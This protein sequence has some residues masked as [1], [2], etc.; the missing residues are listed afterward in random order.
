M[1]TGIT[2]I[3]A[4]QVPEIE[5]ALGVRLIDA[6]PLGLDIGDLFDGAQWT[7]NIDGEAVALPIGDSADAAAVLAMLSGEVE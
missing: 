4:A 1:V 3:N 7:R 5:A 2:A 6:A